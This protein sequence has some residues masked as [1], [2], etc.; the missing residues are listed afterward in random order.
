MNYIVRTLELNRSIFAQ[1]G[2]I[3]PDGTSAIYEYRSGVAK[4]DLE[5]AP[6]NHLTG[7]IPVCEIPAGFYFFTQATGP[8]TDKEYREAAEAVWLES[9]WQGIT[10]K[11]DRILIRILSEDLKIVYQLFREVTG[12][13]FLP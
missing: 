2:V 10:F 6:E 11:N 3:A 8:A 13:A 5:P 1:E 9:L 4:N 7:G 12:G